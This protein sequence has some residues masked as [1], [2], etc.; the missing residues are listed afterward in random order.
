MHPYFKLIMTLMAIGVAFLYGYTTKNKPKRII[1][2]MLILLVISMAGN[3]SIYWFLYVCGP[4]HGHVVDADTGEPIE[5]ASVAGIWEFEYIHI[6]TSKG[7]ANATETVTDANGSFKLGPI[8]A[9]SFWPFAKIDR[10]NLVVFKPGYDSHPPA[11]QRKMKQ[12]PE[13]RR[14]SPDGKYYVGRRAR[15]KA[16]RECEVRLNKAISVEEIRQATI[17]CGSML[18]SWGV[19][20]SKVHGFLKV[21]EKE[22]PRLKYLKE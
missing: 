17:R 9:F 3:Q 16:W 4:Y 7:F 13:G 15:C 10:M 22:N 18:G 11:I 12:P 2:V 19:D 8:L 6:K 1:G 5:G 21:I 20:R 14:T